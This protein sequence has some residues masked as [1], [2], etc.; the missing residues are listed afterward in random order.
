MK[1]NGKV[2]L[3]IAL[4]SLGILFFLEQFGILSALGISVWFVVSLVWPALLVYFGYKIYSNSSSFWGIVLIVVGS[5][6]FLDKFVNVD[7]WGV[8]WPVAIIGAGIYFLLRDEETIVKEERKSDTFSGDSINEDI[9]FWGIDRK[10]VSKD[11]RGGE[12]NCIFGGGK[13]DLSDAGISKDGANLEINCIFGG[14][15]VI[16][17]EKCKVISDGTGVFGGWDVKTKEGK[18]GPELKITGSAVFG[19]VD[20]K[21]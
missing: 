6:S 13:L 9:I 15:D 5:I 1:N 21:R 11:F 17:P 20:I 19:G 8:V 14:L 7:F 3:G 4:I 16:V 12:I 18:E 2:I 10:I